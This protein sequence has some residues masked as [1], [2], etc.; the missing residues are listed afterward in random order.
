MAAG[1][2]GAEK[3]RGGDPALGSAGGEGWRS[4]RTR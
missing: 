4:C 1:L 2:N 3:R